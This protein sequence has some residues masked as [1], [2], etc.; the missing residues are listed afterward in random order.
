MR[1]LFQSQTERIACQFEQLSS[2][3]PLNN[4]SAFVC[5]ICKQEKQQREMA[6]VCSPEDWQSTA[7]QFQESGEA[8]FKPTSACS[9]CWD[10][11]ARALLTTT[12]L[13]ETGATSNSDSKQ[14]K[15]SS[16]VLF[17]EMQLVKCPSC[18]Q[19]WWPV[20]E[21]YR[22]QM[23]LCLG[24]CPSCRATQPDAPLVKPL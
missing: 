15:E 18:S 22:K 10:F 16:D 21:Q 2:E 9:S 8:L 13:E 19:C 4:R 24:L 23:S 11:H 1:C 17:S 20:G 6:Y 3:K 14:R 5:D 12:M 7:K